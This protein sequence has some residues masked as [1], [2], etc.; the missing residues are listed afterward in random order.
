ML[1]GILASF[2]AFEA[3][4]ISARTKAA[5]AV[6]RTNGSKSGKQI[7]NPNFARIPSAIESQIVHLRTRDLAT[8]VS[9]RR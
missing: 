8:G 5:L 6:V 1:A 3:D 7:G 4:L 9:L 2:A